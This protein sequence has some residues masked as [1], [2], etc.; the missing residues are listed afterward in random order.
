VKRRAFL[1]SAAGTME[2]RPSRRA[3]TQVRRFVRVNGLGPDVAFVRV[4][5]QSDRTDF[6]NFATSS[7]VIGPL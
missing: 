7:V 3:V 2:R 1:R 4:P 6:R 5:L